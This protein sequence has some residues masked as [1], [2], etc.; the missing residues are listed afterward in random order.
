MDGFQRS[1]ALLNAAALVA[2]LEP[3]P[4]PAC[5]V[6]FAV[7][8]GTAD[9]SLTTP[10][11]RACAVCSDARSAIN[12]LTSVLV[13]PSAFDGIYHEARAER[14][15]AALGGEWAAA[16]RYAAWVEEAELKADRAGSDACRAAAALIQA[17]DARVAQVT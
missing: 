13:W 4:C 15:G 16:Y 5:G 12:A 14:V 7:R 3:V 17:I 11:Q 1:V 10:E 2:A 6:V 9:W 8:A